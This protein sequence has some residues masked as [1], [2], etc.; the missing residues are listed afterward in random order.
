[1]GPLAAYSLGFP[2]RPCDETPR[3]DDVRRRWDLPG[4]TMPES[5]PEIA[6]YCN[7]AERTLHFP[8]Y[9]NGAVLSPLAV[10]ARRD[11]V[12]VLL[13]GLGGDE[14]LMGTPPPRIAFSMWLQRFLRSGPSLPSWID[15]AF[16]KRIDLAERLRPRTPQNRSRAVR[17]LG[18][19][20]LD[21]TSMRRDAG[22]AAPGRGSSSAIPVGS[23]RG[24]VCLIPDGCKRRGRIRKFILREAMRGLVPDSVR[25]EDAKADFSHLFGETLRLPEA[26]ALFE[27]ARLAGRGWVNARKIREGYSDMVRRYETGDPTYGTVVWPLW[28]TLGLDL[29]LGVSRP[30]P[31][32][33]YA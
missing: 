29:F 2:G 13:T 33:I 12:R 21:C 7:E 23:P 22:Q 4:E 10:R 26:R 8:G 16:A 25:L 11:G 15:P 20:E 9:P 6:F 5:R 1:M 18:H 17:T 24:R 28:M 32:A 14:W 3:I 19:L 27:S 31:E 30:C